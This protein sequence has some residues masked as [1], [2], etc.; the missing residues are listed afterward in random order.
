[1]K[2]PFQLIL[3]LF[4]IS[5]EYKHP[6]KSISQK[7]NYEHEVKKEIDKIEENPFDEGNTKDEDSNNL[8]YQFPLFYFHLKYNLQDTLTKSTFADVI[9]GQFK[10]KVSRNLKIA[11]KTWPKSEQH[12]EK[13]KSYLATFD[14]SKLQRNGLYSDIYEII[15]IEINTSNGYQQ[16]F[17]FNNFFQSIYDYDEHQEFL[18]KM[19]TVQ[20]IYKKERRNAIRIILKSPPGLK[21]NREH[22]FD[23]ILLDTDWKLVART[24]I[25]RVDAF[26]RNNEEPELFK[27]NYSPPLDQMEWDYLELE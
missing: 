3:I 12:F 5:C 4:L 19:K 8:S 9:G 26:Y 21:I 13:A 6:A 25:D 23:Y 10:F 17:Q 1:M 11:N 15:K 7:N 16:F 14:R 24:H 27:W 2:I 20:I 22:T 18:I